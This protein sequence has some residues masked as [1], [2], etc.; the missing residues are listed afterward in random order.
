[1]SRYNSGNPQSQSDADASPPA[2]DSRTFADVS[3]SSE[4]FID[5]LP[6]RI[7]RQ[8]DLSFF[9]CAALLASR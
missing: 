8:A 2:T 9:K 4:V 6:V 5:Y 7:L 1:M 3:G